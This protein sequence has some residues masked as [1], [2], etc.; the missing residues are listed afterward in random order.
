MP[1]V[2]APSDLVDQEQGAPVRVG[3]RIT[4]A[5][6]GEL[7]LADAF[8][9]VFVSLQQELAAPIETGSL[10]VVDG[11]RRDASIA[12]AT[13][14]WTDN[15]SGVR[16]EAREH[17]R[18]L[19]NR[20]GKNLRLRAKMFGLVRAWFVDRGFLEVDTAQRVPCPGL[21]LHLDA[22][23]ADGMHLITSPEFQMKRLLAAGMPRLFQVVHCFRSGEFGTWHNPEFTMLEWYRAFADVQSVVDDTV[24]LLAAVAQGLTGSTTLT[25]GRRVIDVAPPVV[26]MTLCEAF[27]RYANVG[28]QDVFAWAAHDE[29]RYFQTLVE[30]VEPALAAIDRPVLLTDYPS[31]QA[32]LA[33]KSPTDPRVCERFELYVAGVELCNGFGELT[34]PLE[35]RSRFE[36]DLQRR[37]AAGRPSYPLDEAFLRALEEGMPPSAGNAMGL[38]RLLALCLGEPGIGGVMAFPQDRL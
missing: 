33:R 38:D 17:D 7:V 29:D 36:D 14:A 26:R 28:A 32:S 10:V 6:L 35:Q 12:Q 31:S 27:D 4:N 3:G 8:S 15:R 13:I 23:A 16:C 2:L 5:S 20:V 1:E 11:V 21:D 25:L 9:A 19:R 34:D 22:F 24:A 30:H 37:R 18:M